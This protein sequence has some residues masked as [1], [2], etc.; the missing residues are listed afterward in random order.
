M[1]KTLIAT[2]LLLAGNAFAQ[3]EV[4]PFSMDGELGFIATSGNTET[5]SLNA[6]LSAH[7]E[8]EQWSN[9]FLFEGLYKKDDVTLDDD[10][11]ESQTTAQKFFISG[12]GNYKLANPDHRLFAFGSYEDDRFSSFNYQSTVAAGWSQ[13]LWD[14]ETTKFEYSIGPGYSF[15]ETSEGEDADSFIVR[16]AL[17]FNWKISDTATFKQT[18]STEVGEDNT[19][20]K[21]ISSIS[22]KIS[23]SLSMKLTLTFDHNSSVSEGTEKLDTQT[24]ATIV[25]T[26]F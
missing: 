11:S 4:K 10:T 26:F 2:G 21:S 18:M 17:G 19:K 20:S 9:D 6:K 15:A 5:T 8:L 12:Q 22:A 7:Q 23:S 3:E 1:K 24:A 14:N 25:Y 13:K 16:G